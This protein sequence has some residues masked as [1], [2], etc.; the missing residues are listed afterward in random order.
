MSIPVSSVLSIQLWNTLEVDTLPISNGHA[1]RKKHC[2]ETQFKQ[3]LSLER[4][5]LFMKQP[6]LS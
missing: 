5:D 2:Q 1:V 3:H 6:P 4:D